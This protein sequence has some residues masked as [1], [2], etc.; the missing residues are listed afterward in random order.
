MISEINLEDLEEELER[1][2]ITMMNWRREFVERYSFTKLNS[3]K[4][5]QN[6]EYLGLHN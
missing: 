1:A 6:V 4:L 2:D 3:N 5:D